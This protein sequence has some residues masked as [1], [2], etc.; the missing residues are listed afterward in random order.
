MNIVAG[1]AMG[2]WSGANPLRIA[3]RNF[4]PSKGLFIMLGK[5]LRGAREPKQSQ[6]KGL[7]ERIILSVRKDLQSGLAVD[8]PFNMIYYNRLDRG[9]YNKMACEDSTES[10]TEE[11]HHEQTAK[12]GCSRAAV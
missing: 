5:R 7:S 1:L 8:E 4:L 3:P 10:S 6:V 9:S 12:K 2:V 11:N